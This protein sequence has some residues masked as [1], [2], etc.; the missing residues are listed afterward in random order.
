MNVVGWMVAAWAVFGTSAT[1]AAG[2]EI[3]RTFPVAPECTL[4][5]DTS[6]GT[7][8]IEESES[9]GDGQRKFAGLLNGGGPL[10]RL[11]ASGGQV[12]IEPAETLFE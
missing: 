5:L 6:R 1:P 8:D 7:I 2:R 10:I 9:G 12:T 11:K 3:S 4:H